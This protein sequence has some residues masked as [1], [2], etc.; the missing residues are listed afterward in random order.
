L[1]KFLHAQV[2]LQFHALSKEY[3]QGLKEICCATALGKKGKE[4]AGF[5]KNNYSGLL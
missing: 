2:P 4:V 5:C 3:V 1:N